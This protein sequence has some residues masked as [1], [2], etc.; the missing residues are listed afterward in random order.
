ML[1]SSFK[2]IRKLLVL[3]VLLSG[4]ALAGLLQDQPVKALQ[5]CTVCDSLSESCSNFCDSFPSHPHCH[6]CQQQASHCYHTCDPGC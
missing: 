3:A 1:V 4:L 6:V 2:L 5:C